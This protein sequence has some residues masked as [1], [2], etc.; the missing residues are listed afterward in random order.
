[1][2]EYISVLVQYEEVSKQN[3]EGALNTVLSSLEYDGFQ[4][5]NYKLTKDT[6]FDNLT[7]LIK[8]H[9]DEFEITYK[10]YTPGEDALLDTDFESD[11]AFIEGMNI[12]YNIIKGL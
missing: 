11:K 4:V 5:I 3:D 10:D 8:A 6:D 7:N 1:M 2:K 9:K 12:A